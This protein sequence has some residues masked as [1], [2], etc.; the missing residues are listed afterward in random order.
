MRKE[1]ANELCQFEDHGTIVYSVVGR[2]EKILVKSAI[3]MYY[4]VCNV[5]KRES[6]VSSGARIEEGLKG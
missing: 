6:E 4:S 5:S 1:L 3:R 2:G